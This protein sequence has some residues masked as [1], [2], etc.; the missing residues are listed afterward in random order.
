MGASA[1]R[2]SP[3]AG[4]LQLQNRDGGIPTFCRGWGK[5]PFDRSSA[6]LTRAH[7]SAWAA[8]RDE[9]PSRL[10]QEVFDATGRAIAFLVRQQRPDGAWEPLWFGNQHVP[11]DANPTYGTSRV[12]PVNGDKSAFPLARRW[13]L[14]NQND[15]GGWGGGWGTPSSIEETALAV[16]RLCHSDGDDAA[17]DE[18]PIGRGVAWLI[19]HTDHGRS[20]PPLAIGF[21]FAKLWYWEACIR[22]YGR[23]VRWNR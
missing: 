7:T 3:V 10:Q 5:L 15:D 20:F 17:L 14:S 4:L 8:W 16:E 2:Q 19:E 18:N 6:D 11:Q 1:T 21:Y 12:L 22:W 23:S 13:L 9:L